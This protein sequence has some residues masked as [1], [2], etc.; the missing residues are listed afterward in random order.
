MTKFGGW[1]W[2]SYEGGGTGYAQ[3]TFRCRDKAPDKE[4]ARAGVGGQA[5]G[6]FG[7]GFVRATPVGTMLVKDSRSSNK[8]TGSCNEASKQCPSTASAAAPES[9][10]GLFFATS[11][12]AS[13]CK[14]LG[15][16][17]QQPPAGGFGDRRAQKVSRSVFQSCQV[18]LCF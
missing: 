14:V 9:A 10:P 8:Q 4:S 17:V 15:V 1:R 18:Q 16:C 6:P 2:A 12:V 3:H 7:A 13:G 5:S 11:Q